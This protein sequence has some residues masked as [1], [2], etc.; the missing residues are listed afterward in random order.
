ML[1]SGD[2]VQIYRKVKAEYWCDSMTALVGK[3]GFVI[4]HKLN[5]KKMLVVKFA[6]KASFVFPRSALKRVG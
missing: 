1:K 2:K 6:C 4:E 3:T 5:N